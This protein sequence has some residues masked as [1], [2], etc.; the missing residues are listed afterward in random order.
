MFK[1]KFTL[2]QTLAKWLA[3]ASFLAAFM[4]SGVAF[5][6]TEPT[7]SEI[8][9]TAQAGKLD[10]A[11][12]MIQQVL[13]SHPNSA[14]AH[15][16]Q[17]E[18]FARQGKGPLARE[19][20]KTAESLAP[21]LPFAKTEAVQNLRNQIAVERPAQASDSAVKAN[22]TAPTSV[23]ASLSWEL[24]LMLLVGVMGAAYFIFR[25]KPPVAVQAATPAS[26]PAAP[27]AIGSGLNT[28]NLNGTQTFGN[29]PNPATAPGYPQPNYG[30]PGYVQQPAGSGLGGRVMGGLA[31]GLAVGAGLM[32]AQAI[33]KTLTGEHEAGNR[34]AGNLDNAQSPMS[35]N[36]DMGGAD[37]GVSDSG[38]WD[39]GAGVSDSGSWDN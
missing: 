11:Q 20:L 1:S 38:S 13:I 33:G 15:F 16:V 8:Y 37:F 23:P 32:A 12:T 18:L 35:G 25:K 7:L 19:A 31:T 39:D 34:S 26:F 4:G 17:A 22:A 6:Q 14:K 10:Q 5:A 9:A 36:S 21:G 24:P 3:A 27:T 29:S 30:Q 2:L 28:N